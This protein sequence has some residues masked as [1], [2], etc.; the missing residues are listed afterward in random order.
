LSLASPS[1]SAS[2]SSVD[3]PPSHSTNDAAADAV[4]AASREHVHMI[5]VGPKKVLSRV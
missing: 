3:I 2:S 5:L 1:S 4:I